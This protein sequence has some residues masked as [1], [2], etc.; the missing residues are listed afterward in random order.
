M[1]PRLYWQR[2]CRCCSRCPAAYIELRGRILGKDEGEGDNGAAECCLQHTRQGQKD[3]QERVGGEMLLQPP[4][5]LVLA[6]RGWHEKSGLEEEERGRGN[7]F[8]EGNS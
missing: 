5:L 8:W 6:L 7:T 2:H 3:R 1:Q 4:A